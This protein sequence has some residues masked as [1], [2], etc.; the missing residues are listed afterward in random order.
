MRNWLRQPENPLKLAL[1]LSL[2]LILILTL[3]A[4]LI[5]YWEK[6]GI[7]EIQQKNMRLYA[8]SLYQHI[9]QSGIWRGPHGGYFVEVTEHLQR[10]SSVRV[11][12]MGK[13]YARVDPSIYSERIRALTTKRA[14]YRFHL[15]SLQALDTDNRPD[16]WE[17]EALKAFTL[18][19]KEEESTTTS[20][21][22]VQYYRYI[23]PVRLKGR[24]LDCHINLSAALSIDI[25]VDFAYRI[26]SAQIKRS[27]ISFATFGLVMVG[28]V[29]ILTVFFS[30]RI[31]DSFREIK[32]LN[33]SLQELSARNQQVLDSIVDAIMVI[34]E[35]NRVVMVNPSFTE[36]TGLCAD[37][38]VGRDV[39]ELDSPLIRQIVTSR[40]IKEIKLSNRYYT[41]REVAVTDGNRSYGR[42]VILHDVTEDRLTAAVEMAASAAH[43]LRQ[44][45]SI[46]LNIA[47][48]IKAKAG[49]GE[50]HSEEISTLEGQCLR[51]NEVIKKMLRIEQYRKRPY[52]ERLSILDLGEDR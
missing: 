23:A 1:I 38:V 27:A 45:L 40:D 36:L 18:G 7:E 15:T 11:S 31:S 19:T 17:T 25:P 48:I 39:S 51:M 33:Q 43:E 3:L 29:M 6:R 22:G 50:D 14:A 42:L 4:L 37:D 35:D 34:D 49:T 16:P 21:N 5:F 26:Y 9:L 32:R 30:K 24:C 13:E 20:M 12:V 46:I 28:F 41:L 47:E 2:P 44:P 52:T 10:P 8:R